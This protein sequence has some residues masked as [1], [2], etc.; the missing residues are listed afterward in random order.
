[1]TAG[2]QATPTPEQGAPALFDQD[3]PRT[4]ISFRRSF[5][6]RSNLY[7]ITLGPIMVTEWVLGDHATVVRYAT[8]LSIVALAATHLQNQVAEAAADERGVWRRYGW[9]ST[10][11]G[12]QQHWS[13]ADLASVSPSTRCIALRTKQ[14]R[15]VELV[16]APMSN[17]DDERLGEF[18][19]RVQAIAM[20][21]GVRVVPPPTLRERCRQR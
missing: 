9:L 14:G 19:R 4:P 13:W 10:R 12:W 1:M 11:L 20:D 16:R 5:K 21:V 15:T 6:V 8:A 7:P 3:S 17:R 18:A 2:H